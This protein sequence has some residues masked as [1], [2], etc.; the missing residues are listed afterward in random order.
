[1]SH[2]SNISTIAHYTAQVWVRDGLPWAWRFDTARGR[3]MYRALR[4]L[5]DLAHRAGL[6]TPE[7]FCIQRHRIIDALLDRLQPRQVVDLAGGLSPRSVAYSHKHG[8]PGLDVDLPDMVA[9]KGELLGSDAPPG[10]RL[11]A[12]DLVASQDLSADLG[13]ALQRV[14]PTAVITEGLLPYLSSQQQQALFGKLAA[15]L[16][17]CGGGVYLADVHHERDV[18]RLGPVASAFRWTL[19]QFS[20]APQIQLIRDL[21]QGRAMLRRAGFGGLEVHRPADWRRP[22]GLPLRRHDSGLVVYE[23]T[24]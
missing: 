22:L 13:D 23:A 21:E 2:Q 5:F 20:G 11:R 7:L 4:P 16:R 9:L 3:A 8:L 19:H 24:V 18:Q 15:L 1:M 17:W 14:A 6:T 10:Y 12:L